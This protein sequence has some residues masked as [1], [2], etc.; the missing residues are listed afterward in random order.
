MTWQ[1]G[2]KPREILNFIT[3]A[4]LS[5]L[6]TGQVTDVESSLRSLSS[7]LSGFASPVTIHVR[8][9][10]G[11]EGESVDHWQVGGGAPA[12]VAQ[13]SRPKDADVMVVMRP[14]TWLQIAKGQLAP[15]D[16]LFG[17][18]LRIGGNTDTAKSIVQHLS[19]PSLPYVSP[20]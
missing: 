1:G 20:C 3:F 14:E 5:P 15:Y 6:V 17:G 16:A 2:K 11:P 13:H 9:V 8:L 18:K 12:P 19:D 4:R 10:D 7:A